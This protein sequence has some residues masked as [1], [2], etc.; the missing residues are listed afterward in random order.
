MKPNFLCH[1]NSLKMPQNALFSM[2]GQNKILE[3]QEKQKL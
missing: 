3:G 1:V 2:W